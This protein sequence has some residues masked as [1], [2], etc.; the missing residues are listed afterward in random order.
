MKNKSAF[1]A[2]LRRSNAVFQQKLSTAQVEGIEAITD[3]CIG[4]PIEYVAYILATALHETGGKMQPVVENLNYTSD[5]LISKFSRERISIADA[6]KYGRRAGQ[7]ANQQA[8]ANC[9]YGGEW[10]RKNLGNTKQGDGWLMRGRGLV[11]I[12]GRSNYEKFGI[13]NNPD[14]ALDMSMAVYMLVH[15]SVKGLYTG[16]KLGDYLDGGRRDYVGAR[17]VINRNDMA[18]LIAGYAVAIEGALLAGGWGLLS[19]DPAPKKTDGESWLSKLFAA[20]F[21][22]G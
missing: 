2:E 5:A 12:T 7:A 10:G 16:R 8:I 20:I 21:K 18:Q 22:R 6:N 13:A 17:A 19:S 4:L 15:G 11:Q 9:I 1:F 3:A 14:R